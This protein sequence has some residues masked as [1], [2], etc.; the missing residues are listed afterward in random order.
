MDNI[1]KN[2]HKFSGCSL[3]VRPLDIST[4]AEECLQYEENKIKVVFP[5]RITQ[6]RLAMYISAQLNLDE[7]SFNLQ[8]FENFF[9]VAFT[10]TYTMTGKF[11]FN[12]F[13]ESGK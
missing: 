4:K 13:R 1:L 12:L 3:K 9:I 5:K 2:T 10:L 8:S 6:N 7:K 11:D